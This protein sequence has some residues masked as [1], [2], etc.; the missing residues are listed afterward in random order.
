MMVRYGMSY[1]RKQY[2]MGP[3]VLVV[4]VGYFRDSRDGMWP[5]GGEQ[6]EDVVYKLVRGHTV[7][8]W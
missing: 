7:R 6:A 4:V 5:I 8:A 3:C 1:G 2:G